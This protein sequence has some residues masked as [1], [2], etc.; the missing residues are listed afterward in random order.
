MRY[1]LLLSLVMSTL[2]FN[3]LSAQNTAYT[4]ISL[5]PD[6]APNTN[7][8]ENQPEDEKKGIYKPQI[9]VYLPEA[10]KSTGRA[11]ISLP[12]GGYSH[13]AYN[14]EG[15]DFAPFFLEQG[16]AFIVLKY[17]MPFG[18]KEVPFSDVAE[19]IRVTKTNAAKWHIAENKIGIMGSSAGGHLAATVATKSDAATKPAFQIL[20]YPV[21]TMDSTY[22]HKGSR[23]NLLGATPTEAT[24]IAYSNEK[25]VN[26]ATPKA[27]IAFSDDDKAVLP[28]NGTNYYNALQKAGVPASLHIYPSG[29]HGWGFRDNFKYKE[30]F[31]KDLKDWLNSFD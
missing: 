5:W 8:T 7:G 19:A 12:G 10:S 20:L 11:V 18:H 26:A 17:R 27:F 1:L 29:G 21:I 23:K 28:I 6:G 3:P 16:I 14:H 4:D 2:L 22:T 31:L 30:A 9:R 15:Y 13:L 25:Q 24:S